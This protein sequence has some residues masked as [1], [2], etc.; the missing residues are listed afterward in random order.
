LLIQTPAF[1]GTTV[2]GTWNVYDSSGVTLI[3]SYVT[4]E[5]FP[6]VGPNSGLSIESP[7]VFAAAGQRVY[8][9]VNY[10]GSSRPAGVETHELILTG[11][12]GG[13]YQIYN[14]DDYIADLYKFTYPMTPAQYRE[15]KAN[16]T[17]KIT[18]NDGK[19]FIEGWVD[20]IRFKR[21]LRQAEIT[22]IT[23]S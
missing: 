6:T 15:L 1:S 9:Q 12:Q 14:Q 23:H 16:P 22:L 11:A 13:I 2:R 21:K 18:A 4:E 3:A 10:F 8:L 19:N 20:D 5:L 17:M 7:L